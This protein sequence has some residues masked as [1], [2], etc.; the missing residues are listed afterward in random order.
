VASA[1]EKGDKSPYISVGK[2]TATL[3]DQ[4]RARGVVIVDINLA[5]ANMENKDKITAML[6]LLHDRYLQILSQLASSTYSLNRPIDLPFL[7]AALQ[8]ATNKIA[9]G[10][11]ASVQITNAM[12]QRM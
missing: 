4:M 11:I 1:E 3:F 9:G 5:L 6:P 8:R 10:E 2:L 12:T 7:T